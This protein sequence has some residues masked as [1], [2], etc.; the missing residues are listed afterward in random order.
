VSLE[1]RRFLLE[2]GTSP[3]FGARELKRAIHRFLTQPLATLVIES[4]IAP[5]STAKVVLSPDNQ[6]LTFL[7]SPPDRTIVSSR[8]TILL[9]DD[10][11]DF[12]R[13]LS[14]ELTELT[15]WRVKTAQSVAEARQIGSTQPVDFALLD[16]ILPDG[17]GIDL[18]GDLKHLDAKIHIAIMTGAELSSIEEEQCR[19]Y[20]FDTVNKPFLPQHVVSLIQERLKRSARAIA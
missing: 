15:N 7:T 3:E 19:K 17:N 13:L 20:G 2:K 12:L 10:N 18:G 1:A 14:L 8:P 6:S 5:G 11:R 4:K 16:L 9:V